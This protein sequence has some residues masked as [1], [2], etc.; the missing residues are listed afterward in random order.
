M[1]RSQRFAPTRPGAK[2]GAFAPKEKIS[3]R[4]VR[5]AYSLYKGYH[6]IQQAT[7]KAQA[8]TVEGVFVEAVEDTTSPPT[9]AKIITYPIKLVANV[10]VEVVRTVAVDW[11]KY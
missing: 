9:M 3:T 5:A 4:S 1:P 11:W 2:R 6:S 7:A 8:R 10:V